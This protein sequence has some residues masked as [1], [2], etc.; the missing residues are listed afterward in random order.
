[1]TVDERVAEHSSWRGRGV[2]LDRIEAEIGRL[3]RA[4]QRHGHA[5]ARTLNLIVSPGGPRFDERID[6]VLAELG[7]HSPSRTLVL[8]RHPFDRLDAEAMLDCK[9]D[10]RS[11]RVG[12]CHD[13][14]SLSAD[15]WRLGHAASL[16]APL[17]LADLPTVLWLPDPGPPIPD[18]RLLDRAQHVL[19]DSGSVPV[20]HRR[21][22]ELAQQIRVHDL[23]WGRLEFWR[24]ATAAAFEPLE[25]RRLLAQTAELEVAYGEGAASAAFLIAGWVAARA[26][27]RPEPLKGGV[28]VATRADGG[29]V[30]LVLRGDPAAGECG[31]VESLTFRAGS[32]EVRVRRG[33]ATSRLR[34]LFAEALQPL[35]AYARGYLEAVNAAAVMRGPAEVAANQDAA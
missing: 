29:M 19:V 2:G 24:A 30:T 4:H 25:R 8:R 27:W 13:R 26:G 14:V 22:A 32:E 12:I 33:G 17:L 15:E 21:V 1:M 31:G 23:T 35:P 3:H 18:P 16:V 9:L 7:A 5:M 10:D 6:A 11:G 20:S 28:G 34:D